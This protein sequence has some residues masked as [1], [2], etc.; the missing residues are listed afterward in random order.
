MNRQALTAVIT[1]MIVSLLLGACQSATPAADTP[2]VNTAPI[3]IGTSLPLTGAR[4]EAGSATQKGYQVWAAMVNAAGGLLGRQ[5]NLTVLDNTSDQDQVTKDYETLISQNKVDLLLG[6][7]S[8]FLT[9]PSSKTAADHGYAY[10]EPSGGSPDVFNRSL[11]NVFFAQPAVASRQ[12]D[13]FA[14]YL[15]GLPADQR[16]KTFAIVTSDDPFSIGVMDRLG[17]LLSDGGITQAV[18]LSYPQAQTDFTDIAAQ[19]AKLD[20]DLII[21]GTQYEDSVAQIQAYQAAKYQPRF[22]YFTSGPTISAPFRQ[23]VGSATEGVF[24]SAAWFPDGKDFQNADFTAKYIEMFGGTLGDIPEDAANGFTA[25]QVLQQA[26]ENI[27]SVDNAAL[28]AELHRSTYKTV[29][30]SLNFDDTG[31]PQG[32]FML[33]QWKGDNFLVVGPSDRAEADPIPPPKPQW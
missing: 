5:V 15:L 6:T 3:Q 31:A 16:P 12:A 33:V 18:R 20:P 8:S 19:I 29:V 27:K 13:P 22:A 11:K 9:I 28:I 30:G 26:V 10:V 21:G 2:V 25:G 4:A 17:A 24:S 1:L 23:A 7:Q 14:L 32:S